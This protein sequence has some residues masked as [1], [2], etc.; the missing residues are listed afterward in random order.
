MALAANHTSAS[1][2][3]ADPADQPLVL[4]P[5]ELRQLWQAYHE[6]LELH[7][8]EVV[9][10]EAFEDAHRLLVEQ[11]LPLRQILKDR[12]HLVVDP[13]AEVTW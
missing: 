5:G 12:E 9:D 2:A 8:A 1:A 7:R 6:L 10:D 11:V 13:N 4:N 3:Y